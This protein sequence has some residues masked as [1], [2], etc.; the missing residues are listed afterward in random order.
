MVY[1]VWAARRDVIETEREQ[2]AQALR[3]LK[4]ARTW[5]LDHIDRVI[6]AAQAT[7]P[8]ATGIY[9]AYYRTLNFEFDTS[10]QAG[11]MRYF[12]ELHAIGAIASVPLVKP[13]VFVVSR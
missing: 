9:E 12:Q 1:A 6:A 11:L 3:V 4:D 10:A 13:E 8:R 2:V 7:H 5:G